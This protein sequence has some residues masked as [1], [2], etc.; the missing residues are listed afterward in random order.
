VRQT[1]P[2]LLDAVRSSNLTVAQWP[3]LV[4]SEPVVAPAGALEVHLLRPDDELADV[5][6]AVH[7][8]FAGTDVV[9]PT[10]ATRHPAMMRAGLLAVAGAYDGRGAVVAEP[11]RH[12]AWTPCSWPRGRSRDMRLRAR[13][14]AR[15][16][17]ACIAE[18]SAA[19]Q[20]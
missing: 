10:P 3:L 2:S 4:L 17:T 18:P 14:F 15:V 11:R 6:A 20:R 19:H 7:A 12:A 16:G 1:T 9:D 5:M 8:A 13:R